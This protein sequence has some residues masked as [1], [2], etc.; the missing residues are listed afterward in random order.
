MRIELISVEDL[1]G[2]RWRLALDEING[3]DPVVVLECLY[4]AVVNEWVRVADVTKDPR[5]AGVE[6]RKPGV[7]MLDKRRAMFVLDGLMVEHGATRR[8][9]D[10]VE[11][12]SSMATLA[13]VEEVT[14]EEPAIEGHHRMNL[15]EY[16]V[17]VEAAAALATRGL[18]RLANERAAGVTLD[19]VITGAP[20]DPVAESMSPEDAEHV[21]ATQPLGASA[22][23]RKLREAFYLMQD[24]SKAIAAARGELDHLNSPQHRTPQY[25]ARIDMF[26]RWVSAIGE[27]C[28]AFV[29]IQVPDL[30]PGGGP[31][32]ADKPNMITLDR[33]ELV[34]I[35]RHEAF[36]EGY[37]GSSHDYL[38]K[39][40]G[41]AEDFKVHDWVIWAMTAAV[42]AAFKKAALP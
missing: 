19:A 14:V 33:A 37:L 16:L 21:V 39:S 38:P 30:S 41:V 28:V 34:R 15:L 40:A 2:S 42:H 25:A 31:R 4:S 1:H 3:A 35:A 27:R 36:R 13:G 18:W 29:T 26:D 22:M 32:L 9:V 7:M 6:W 8:P 10:L 11:G 17:G 20:S 24:M 12:I 23:V 5:E